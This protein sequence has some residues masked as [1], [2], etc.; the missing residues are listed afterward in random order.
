M[1]EEINSIK[2][3]AAAPEKK[4]GKKKG[5]KKAVAKKWVEHELNNNL[6]NALQGATVIIMPW[7]TQ[8]SRWENSSVW[9]GHVQNVERRHSENRTFRVHDAQSSNATLKSFFL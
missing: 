8:T 3:K 5:T 1:I 6:W 9:Y 7:T 4:K 2:Q